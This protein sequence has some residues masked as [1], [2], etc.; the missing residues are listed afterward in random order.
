MLSTYTLGLASLWHSGLTQYHYTLWRTND[1]ERQMLR[2]YNILKWHLWNEENVSVCVGTM[3]MLMLTGAFHMTLVSMGTIRESYSFF[4]FFSFFFL[5]FFY[6]HR[7]I[8]SHILIGQGPELV[9]WQLRVLSGASAMAFVKRQGP[10]T[11]LNNIFA[12]LA[13]NMIRL[14]GHL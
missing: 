11:D 8:E 7:V 6:S 9:T 14:R 13:S 4:L 10:S 3:A 5:F 1:Q 2:I 12:F